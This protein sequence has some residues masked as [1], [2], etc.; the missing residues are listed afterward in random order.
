MDNTLNKLLVV[1]LENI[2]DTY[3]NNDKNNRP[4]CNGY[5]GI[6]THCE[7]C[8]KTKGTHKH[9]LNNELQDQYKNMDDSG[10]MCHYCMT[11]PG[12]PHYHEEC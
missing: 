8:K 4:K 11:H 7:Y 2:L 12:I 10:T 3:T 5:I 1:V 9:F 6:N